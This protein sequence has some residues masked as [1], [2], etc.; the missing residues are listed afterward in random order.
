MPGDPTTSI[1]SPVGLFSPSVLVLQIEAGIVSVWNKPR[2]GNIY[3]KFSNF[4]Y[5]SSFNS[6]HNNNN[7]DSLLLGINTT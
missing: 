7:N 3:Q 6:V 5:F 1:I 2:K 4:K